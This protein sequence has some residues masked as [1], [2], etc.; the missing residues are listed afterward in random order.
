M[1]DALVLGSFDTPQAM[2][3]SMRQAKLL[4]KSLGREIKFSTKQVLVAHV[5]GVLKGE[6][7]ITATDQWVCKAHDRTF[8]SKQALGTHRARMHKRK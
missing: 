2:D 6:H 8:P 3:D 1:K 5:G 4:G 7:S